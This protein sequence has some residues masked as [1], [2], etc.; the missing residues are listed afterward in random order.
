MRKGR[1]ELDREG[2]L[3]YIPKGG[4]SS[5]VLKVTSPILKMSLIFY[6]LIAII[7][8]LSFSLIYFIN[9]NKQVNAQMEEIMADYNSEMIALSTYVGKQAQVLDNKLNEIATLETAQEDLNIQIKDLSA[10]LKII[11][12]NILTVFPW[13][14][15]QLLQT[16]SLSLQRIQRQSLLLWR[17]CLHK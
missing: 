9:Q 17:Y 3:V 6:F 12:E 1:T 7:V 11:A 10:Q 16:M 13:Q 15:L 4:K 2:M 14:A 5:K 8:C